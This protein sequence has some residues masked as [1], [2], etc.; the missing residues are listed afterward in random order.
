[1]KAALE[2]HPVMVG[3]N[4]MDS[5]MTYPKSTAE[6]LQ[7]YWMRKELGAPD[8]ESAPP[9]PE[10]SHGTTSGNEGALCLDI[11]GV[12]LRYVHI[13]TAVPNAQCVNLDA[14]VYC[15]SNGSAP[16]VGVLVR[17]KSTQ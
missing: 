14:F 4:Q 6:H 17:V 5:C 8:P 10:M 2:E 12:P 15:V 7:T 9:L 16:F 13:H 3:E 11:D 1:M